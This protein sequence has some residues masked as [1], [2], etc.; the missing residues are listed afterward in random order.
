MT[1]RPQARHLQHKTNLFI[2]YELPN[3]DRLLKNL[4]S[5]TE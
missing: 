3:K 5:N 1:L 2:T 4:F